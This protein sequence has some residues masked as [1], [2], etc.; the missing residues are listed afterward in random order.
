MIC[1]QCKTRYA[2]FDPKDFD[3][4]DNGFPVPNH[5]KA[6][7]NRTEVFN[8]DNIGICSPDCQEVLDLSIASQ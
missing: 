7:A 2:P 8:N 5:D 6:E 1:S 3:R 4:M